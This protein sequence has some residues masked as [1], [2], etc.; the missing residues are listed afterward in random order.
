MKRILPVFCLL[1]IKVYRVFFS[2]HFGG[3]CRFYPS[4]SCYAERA[5]L[6]CSFVKAF[7]L[8]LRR[9]S[10]CHFFGPFGWDPVP[11]DV[12]RKNNIGMSKEKKTFYKDIL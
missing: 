6:S 9:L 10:K 2:V 11:E 12:Q 7:Y 3:A 1:L 4:C 5:F 8:V